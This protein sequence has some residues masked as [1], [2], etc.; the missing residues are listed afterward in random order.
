[1]K[2][3][4]VLITVLLVSILTGCQKGSQE[5]ASTDTAQQ[6]LALDNKVCSEGASSNVSILGLNKVVANLPAELSLSSGVNCDDAKLALWKAGDVVIGYGQ[7]ISTQFNGSGS[8][9]LSVE[10]PNAAEIN[11]LRKISSKVDAGTNSVMVIQQSLTVS[12]SGLVIAGPQAGTEGFSYSYSV[13][14]PAGSQF[15]SIHWDFGD[16]TDV[17]SSL[18]PVSHGFMTGVY[19]IQARI[20]RADASVEVI[21]QPVTI[22]PFPD[23]RFCPLDQLAINGPTEIPEQRLSDFSV[24]LSTCLTSL[25]PTV[26]WNF[27]DGTNSVTGSSVRHSFENPGSYQVT[28]Q[29]SV[30]G[31]TITLVRQFIVTQV[32]DPMPPTNPPGPT[33]APN[34]NG[35][36]QLGATR[37]VDGATSIESIACGMD[38]KKNMNYVDKISQTCQMVGNYLEWVNQSTS[39][40]LVSEG[41]C[42]GQSCVLVTEGT[43]ERLL[44]GASRVL[45]T[46]KTP[47][48]SCDQ[49]KVTRVCNNGVVSGSADAKYLTC[50][51][52][53]GEFGVHGTVKVGVSIGSLE[54]A[55][56][57]SFGETGV[58]STYN[59][60]ADKSCQ[61]GQVVTGAPRQGDLVKD[62]VC[63]VYQ[64]APTEQYTACSLACGGS[65]SRIFECK[66]DKGE[67]SDSVRCG[68]SMP[69]ESRVCDGD[70]QSVFKTETKITSEEANTCETCPKNQIGIIVKSREVST[71][72]VTACVDHKIKV[73]D[74][75]SYGPWVKESYCQ[76]FTPKRCS[77]DSLSNDQA[78][79]RYQWLLKCQSE[80]PMI[81][82]FLANFDD[83]KGNGFGLNT[84]GRVLYPTFLD[85]KTKKTWKAP[86]DPK[87]SCQIPSTVYIAGVCVSSCSTPEQQILVD[88]EGQMK[89]MPFI[90][91][92]L[93]KIER[94]KTLGDK[95]SLSTQKVKSLKVDSWVTEIEDAQHE[96]LV[97]KMKSGGQLKVTSNHPI[98]SPEGKMKL[99]IDYKVGESLVKLGGQLDPIISIEKVPYFGKVYNLFVKSNAPKQNIV[100]I[101]GY[102]NGTAFYQNEGADWVN[103]SLFRESLL[104]GA[105]N[106]KKK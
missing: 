4:M 11:Q 22:L 8:Y 85:S 57:C 40:T 27:G 62:G 36:S 15:L 105:F 29:V 98:L 26:I 81:G 24:S 51:S 2:R 89:Y 49:V 69:Q 5:S 7:K 84:P 74:N 50:Q 3:Q 9:T 92:Y 68:A 66:N 103:R 28:A 77:N 64:W 70:P 38:G 21:S 54:V 55:K 104:K 78:H 39:K 52:G 6:T 59:Q 83:I 35:C 80:V 12:S 65:Q 34:P 94:V 60:I 86:T 67:I 41:A 46:S 82:E 45:Y 96:I 93:A 13:A 42:M 79:K 47:V 76:D 102:L 106:G 19:Q 73:T 75:V 88:V 87:A 37:V 90:D 58:F 99:A 31:T 16:G 91:A 48:G 101:G 53:C 100:V 10:I 63:P 56:T 18:N 72:Q 97:F 43:E 1:M 95:S 61:N 32:I 33:P 23:G 20:T 25:S 44:D 14:A 17:V 30:Y 71:T